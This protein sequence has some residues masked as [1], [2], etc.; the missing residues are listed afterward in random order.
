MFWNALLSFLSFVGALVVVP[1]TLYE[2]KT[3]GLQ[4][5]IC[6]EKWFKIRYLVIVMM[7][8]AWSKL[9]E[10]T[11]TVFLALRKRPIMLLH[12][13]HHVTVLLYVWWSSFHNIGSIGVIFAAMNLCVHAI[14]YGYYC[15]GA[16][17][18]RPPFPMFITLLQIAQMVFGT[19]VVVQCKTCPS[20]EANPSTYWSALI[21]YSSYAVL[22][23]LFFLNRYIWAKKRAPGQAPDPRIS[24]DKIY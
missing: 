1:F 2:I 22:F 20:A 3:L 9:P 23:L 14:M 6:S 8:F 7:S 13:Y 21:M 5:F 19:Y 10:L 11:D 4:A 16:M 17:G 24:K 15:L 18:Y 12:W